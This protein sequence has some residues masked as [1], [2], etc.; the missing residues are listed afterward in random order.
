MVKKKDSIQIIRNSDEVITKAL[1]AKDLAIQKALNS[2]NVDEVYKAQ[3]YLKQIQKKDDNVEPKSMIID[4]QQAWGAQ[5]YKNKNYNLSYEMLRAMARTDIIKPIISTRVEQV[6]DFCE[7]QKDKYS[8]GF[9]IQPR[10]HRKDNKNKELTPDQ[11]RRIEFLTEFIL[12]CGTNAN[13]WHGDN[14]HSFTRKM[15]PDSLS[16]DQ[17]CFEIIPDRRGFPTEFLAVDSAIYRI[18]D[19]LND[20][21]ESVRFSQAE[22][23]QGYYPSYVQVYQGRILE[24]FYPWE[25]CFGIRNPQSSIFANGYGRSELEDLIE[26]V[27]SML[28]AGQYNANY[29]KVGSNPKGILKV[30][31]NV[32]PG[33]LEEFKSIWQATM[34]GVRNS[35]KM[36]VIEADKMDFISTQQSNKDMEWGKYFEFLIKV[37][38]AHYK[39]DPSEINFPLSGSSENAPMFEGNNAARLK[40][41]KDKGLKPLLKTYQNWIN[42]YIIHRLDP[43]YEFSFQG[44]N[45][46]DPDKELEHDIKAVQNFMTVNEVRRKRGM[47]DIEGGDVI[48][49][50]VMQQSKMADMQMQ[51]GFDNPGSNVQDE[52]DYSKSESN[53]PIFDALNEDIV[54]I[55]N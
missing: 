35:H 44:L 24:E 15:I 49:N 1:I 41:S 29:F 42:K 36:A 5:G 37:A 50:P 33:R 10:K 6:I 55:F 14:F 4:P 26:N 12:N 46:E 40:F 34:T 39:M 27:T 20:D 38:S 19:T 47:E 8:T 22:P 54:K 48:L 7:P 2:G 18:A 30:T 21:R 3:A 31:G 32:N 28:N 25:L 11:E 16:M 52:S 53:N 51:M 13:E 9:V 17:A 23:I 43:D 45:A